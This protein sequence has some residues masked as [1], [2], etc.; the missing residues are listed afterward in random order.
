LPIEGGTETQ[1]E[2]GGENQGILRFVASPKKLGLPPGEHLLY[3]VL[4]APGSVDLPADHFAGTVRSPA[5]RVT[6]SDS[7][8]EPTPEALDLR[9]YVRARIA[10]ERGDTKAAELFLDEGIKS[11]SAAPISLI[12]KADLHES[13]EQFEEAFESLMRA[14]ELIS[15]RNSQTKEFTEPPTYLIHRL[16]YLQKRISEK[17]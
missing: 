10:A 4:E 3:A 12:L 6:V 16:N 13:S 8:G 15:E 1:L 17:E 5:V 14:F 2:L 7:S 9:T 11:N